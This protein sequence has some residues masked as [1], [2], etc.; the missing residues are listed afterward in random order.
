MMWLN[1][2]F[3]IFIYTIFNEEYIISNN[4]QSTLW[5]SIKQTV[6]GIIIIRNKRK[7]QQVNQITHYKEMKYKY[8]I[9]KK[10]EQVLKS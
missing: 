5:S 2:I 1:S 10:A 4:I 8:M 9:H 3:Y 7:S 6:I